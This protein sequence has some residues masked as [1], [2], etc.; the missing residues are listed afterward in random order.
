MELSERL[1]IPP[2]RLALR[3]FCGHAVEARLSRRR[4]YVTPEALKL[5][6]SA[7]AN[8]IQPLAGKDS[9]DEGRRKYSG[10]GFRERELPAGLIQA[11]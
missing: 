11:V 6:R 2:Q 7:I 9:W 4:Y 8:G 10:G 5:A 3:S 1:S